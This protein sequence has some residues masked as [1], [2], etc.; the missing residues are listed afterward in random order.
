MTATPAISLGFVIPGDLNAPTGGCRYDREV[1]GR[2]SKYGIQTNHIR[3][4]HRYPFPR[5]Q[6]RQQTAT[7]LAAAQCD[8]LLIDGLAFG[9][10]S[11]IEIKA[12]TKPVVVLLHHPLADET[13][14]AFD[15]A[16]HLFAQEK[17]NLGQAQ[18]I[19]VTSLATQGRLVA[20][21]DVGAQRIVVA[22]PAIS[23][24]HNLPDKPL[25]SLSTPCESPCKMLA[26]GSISP[27]KN[28][29]VIIN[30][31]SQIHS[32][33][34]WILHIAGRCDDQT[35]TRRL[36]ELIQRKGL[37][38]QIVLLDAISEQ[39]LEKLYNESDF[40]L[41]PS[42][43]EGFGMALTEALAY[44]LPVLA[45]AH[46][47]SASPFAG[48]AVVLLDPF[49]SEPWVQAIEQWVN[50]QNA[51]TKAAKAAKQASRSLPDWDQ[52]TLKIARVVKQVVTAETGSP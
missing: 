40:L 7:L 22:E 45:S 44:G 19:V 3:V 14:L 32:N 31:L 50:Q 10:F 42:L 2:F 33:R 17:N 1:L 39:D 38:N 23:K 35:E 43:Y 27:R 5:E 34:P 9:A 12:L 36:T 11:D 26:V 15:I 46:I 48:L 4:S 52:T 21:Y 16:Q 18:A 41:F 49:K 13:G 24:P 28:Y 29:E 6:D 8:C 51:F 47:P 30:A 37:Q 25:P 20:L